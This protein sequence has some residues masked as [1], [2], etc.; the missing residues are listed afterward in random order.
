MRALKQNASEVVAWAAAGEVVTI[1]DRGRPVAQLVPLPSTRLAS[2]TAAS[3]LRPRK[4]SLTDLG[5]AP[6]R[7]AGQ[8]PLS[9]VLQKMRDAERF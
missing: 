2:L 6:K 1:T 3:Q 5:P 9:Q 4:R 8:P 7:R